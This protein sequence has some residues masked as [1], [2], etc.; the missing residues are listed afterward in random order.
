MVASSQTKHVT[1]WVQDEWSRVKHQLLREFGWQVLVDPEFTEPGTALYHCPR[2]VSKGRPSVPEEFSEDTEWDI[3]PLPAN[4]ASQVAA[5]LKKGCL[6]QKAGV[7]SVLFVGP[8]IEQI[9]PN[10]SLDKVQEPKFTHAIGQDTYNFETWD[11]FL[12]FLNHRDIPVDVS[13][14]PDRV[15]EHLESF[16]Y[17]CYQHNFATDNEHLANQHI[18]AIRQS[19]RRGRTV[20]LSLDELIA[21]KE[22]NISAGK[23]TGPV[24]G[25]EEN[26][27]A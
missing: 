13:Q 4:N 18:R 20:H 14:C 7:P 15:K 23:Q 24:R 6:F 27:N 3:T 9:D 11:A 26:I 8:Q 22:T 10:L 19:L 25:Q 12:W 17:R 16:K 2:V 21:P 1:R 5:R